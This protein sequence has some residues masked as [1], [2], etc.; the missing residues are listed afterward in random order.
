MFSKNNKE[1]YTMN[2]FIIN[3]LGIKDE[4]IIIDDY[5]LD[6][7][8]NEINVFVSLKKENY[9]CPKCGSMH[10][11]VHDYRNIKITHSNFISK[12]C[13]IIYLSLSNRG[14]RFFCEAKTLFY[15]FNSFFVIVNILY[16]KNLLY[17]QK[18]DKIA[19]KVG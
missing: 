4:N 16:K 15:C 17:S 11:C 1:E 8:K 7:D 5:F 12:K 6:E 2:N 19:I 13:N 14:R 3:L 10:C 9:F 18:R